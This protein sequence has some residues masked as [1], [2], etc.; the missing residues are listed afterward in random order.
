MIKI[1]MTIPRRYWKKI[2][3]CYGI[4]LLVFV[5]VFIGMVIRDGTRFFYQQTEYLAKLV[6]LRHN[7]I[8]NETE[9][10]LR[11]VEEQDK[12]LILSENDCNAL[13]ASLKKSFVN[14]T[15]FAVIDVTGEPKCSALE[16]SNSINVA[17]LPYIQQVLHS[18][19][20]EVGRYQTGTLTGEPVLPFS[21]PIKNSNGEIKAVL[22]AFLSL[23][24]VDTINQELKLPNRMTI[25]LVDRNGFVLS[26]VGNDK[27]SPGVNISESQLFKNIIT[28]DGEGS[29]LYK[30]STNEWGLYSFTKLDQESLDYEVYS[31]IGLPNLL[32]ANNVLL[33]CFWRSIL[34]SIV[35]VSPIILVVLYFYKRIR[36]VF[37][38]E[39]TKV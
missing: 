26:E 21:L 17:Y 37:Y 28:K 27:I 31:I 35:G 14:Y 6:S 19:D 24:W 15:N 36:G 7:Q 18:R 13:M 8:V 10:L 25:M 20:F 11:F 4:F 2:V 23:D 30:G 22:A 39:E 9:R 32:I 29:G 12:P 34:V 38:R 16:I 1:V 33:S 3:I 5:P